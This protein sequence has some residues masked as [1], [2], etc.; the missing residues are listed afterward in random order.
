MREKKIILSPSLLSC[1]F[2]QAG[3]QLEALERAG[4]RQIHLDVMDG[5]FVPNISFGQVVIRSLRKCTKLFFDTHLMITEPGRYIDD[6]VKAGSDRITVHLESCADVG[7]VL[8]HIAAAG[9]QPALSVKPGT[10]AEAAFPYLDRCAA[11]LVMTVEPGFGGQ[12]FMHEMLPKITQ[13]RDEL[14]RRNLSAVVQVD[15][16]IDCA[17]APLA[18]RAGASDLV[19]G[20]SVFG[21]PD[22]ARAARE[23]LAAANG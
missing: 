6:F 17:T 7:P 1:D 13:F 5:I 9:V 18:V 11:V 21:K 4:I 3:V 16:G 8:D 12:G 10:P 2:A 14:A 23:L 19:A 15:G 20:S 22:P